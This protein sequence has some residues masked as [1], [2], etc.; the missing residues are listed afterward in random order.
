MLKHSTSEENYIKA[1]FHLQTGQKPVNTNA[2]A[3]KLNTKPAS[4]TDML[5]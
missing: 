4:V 2:L 5:K 1:I 3:E